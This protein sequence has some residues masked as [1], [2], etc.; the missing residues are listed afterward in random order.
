[1]PHKNGKTTDGREVQPRGEG[2]PEPGP[3]IAVK[4]M[5]VRPERPAEVPSA[6]Q[7][8]MEASSDGEGEKSLGLSQL[9]AGLR[10]VAEATREAAE[11]HGTFPK[12]VS[13]YM[14]NSMRGQKC[15]GCVFYEGGRQEGPCAVVKG[16]VRA[17]A[18]CNFHIPTGKTARSNGQ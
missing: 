11:K 4:M 15:K 17:E 7:M 16:T 1:M 10:M 18:V 6:E 13:G 14:P 2:A 3:S 8:G 5:Q 9:P 12:R